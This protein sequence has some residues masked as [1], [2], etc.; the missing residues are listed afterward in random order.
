MVYYKQLIAQLY[1]FIQL[2]ACLT[3]S[4]SEFALNIFYNIIL[5]TIRHR[6]TNVLFIVKRN[7]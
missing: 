3:S 6:P 7:V 5:L 4:F 1:S 2:C